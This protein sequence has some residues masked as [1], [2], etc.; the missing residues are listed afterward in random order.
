MHTR[1]TFLERYPEFA[2]TDAAVVDAALDEAEEQIDSDVWGRFENAGH[3]A[4]TA[5]LLAD[6]PFGNAA[7]LKAKDGSEPSTIYERR[8]RRLV[9]LVGIGQA[10]A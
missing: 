9:K 8:Y 2:E 10:R 4:L 1:T 6:S 3:G 5:H 7:K